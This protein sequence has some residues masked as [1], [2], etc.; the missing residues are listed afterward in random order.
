MLHSGAVR[1]PGDH[2]VRGLGAWCGPGL[3]VGGRGPSP[4][5]RRA[6]EQPDGPGRAQLSARRGGLGAGGEARGLLTPAWSRIWVE[7]GAQV[8]QRGYVLNMKWFVRSS[9]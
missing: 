8:D 9:K 3:P 5:A 2:A 4:L 1:R 6:A 7:Q